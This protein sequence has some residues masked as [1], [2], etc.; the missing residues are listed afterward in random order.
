VE[1]SDGKYLYFSRD[2]ATAAL[3][4]LSLDSRAATEEP[5]LESLQ[6]WGWWTLGQKGIFFFEAAGPERPSAARLKFLDQTTNRVYELAK[7]GKPVTWQTPTL[8]VSPDERS[9]VF[10]QIDDVGAD[11]MLMEGFR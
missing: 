11:I 9:V 3:W 8:T 5:V 6:D 4:R 7:T 1:S 2:R 10:T